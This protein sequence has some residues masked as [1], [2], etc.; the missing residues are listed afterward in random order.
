[1]TRYEDTLWTSKLTVQA[2]CPYNIIDDLVQDTRLTLEKYLSSFSPDSKLSKLDNPVKFT[3]FYSEVYLPLVDRYPFT[4]I[5]SAE[6]IYK[7][8]SYKGDGSLDLTGLMKG[9]FV[10]ILEKRL[11]ALSLCYL[12]NFGGDGVVLWDDDV[13]IYEGFTSHLIP[14]QMRAA[15]FTS[16]NGS[17]R[18]G[19]HIEGAPREVQATVIQFGLG[20]SCEELDMLATSICAGTDYANTNHLKV[21]KYNSVSNIDNEI[22][23]V[24]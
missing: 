6:K 10:D 18:R 17:K 24:N 4:G 1:M 21:F 2:D 15:F 7:F 3:E 9:L 20:M 22:V 23:G 13:I 14:A 11:S 8:G 5:V 19:K 12:I 16:A